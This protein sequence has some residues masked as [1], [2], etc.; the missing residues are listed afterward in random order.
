MTAGKGLCAALVASGVLLSTVAAARADCLASGLDGPTSFGCEDGAVGTITQ[1]S[2]LIEYDS[3]GEALGFAVGSG[4][5]AFYSDDLGR[6]GV[7]LGQGNGLYIDS[8]QG[9]WGLVTRHG[10]S[11]FIDLPESTWQDPTILPAEREL[12]G[13]G[14]D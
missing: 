8:D 2:G 9:A 4:G 1:R 12:L 13:L 14:L 10:N 7:V 5:S 6:S 11:L 3:G